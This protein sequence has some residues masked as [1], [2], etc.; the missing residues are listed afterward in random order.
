MTEVNFGHRKVSPEE[1]TELVGD[2]FASVASRYDVMNDFMS[3]GTHRL[4]KRMV[5]QSSGVRPGH[6][7]LDLAGG[8]GDMSALFA[9]EVGPTGRVV[10]TDLNA[11]MMGVGQD[12][13]Y[14]QGHANVASCRSPAEALPFA[15]ES[16]DVACISFGIRNFTDKE[17][18]L[19]ELLRVLKPGAPL[20]V[21][22]FSTPKDPLLKGAYKVFQSLWPLAGQ[23]VV[24][25]AESYRYLI[26]SIEVHP[27]QKALKQMFSDAGFTEVEYH[28]LI[29][30]VA[31]I[32]RGVKPVAN[33]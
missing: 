7:V 18:A 11:E 4:F 15:D 17:G 2:V 32:H 9:K 5:I 24:G 28:D 23:A 19:V 13:L 33:L 26:E 3:F 27:D 31:A 21:L 30:G 25:D 12:R 20:L 1:K 29:G 14:N 6:M 10:L 8:T 22:E 16:F